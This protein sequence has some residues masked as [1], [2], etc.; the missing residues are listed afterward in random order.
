[1]TIHVNHLIDWAGVILVGLLFL[2]TFLGLVV[3]NERQVGIVVKNSPA[4]ACPR[5]L[6]ALHGEAGYQADTLAPA[7]TLATGLAV[8]RRQ[9]A[10]N[11]SPSGRIALVVAADGA[12]NPPQ[13]ISA[14]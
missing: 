1:M 5:Q 6:V 4:A 13:R 12:S 10:G 2:S 11:C 3:I 8:H 9:S 14:K 7:G